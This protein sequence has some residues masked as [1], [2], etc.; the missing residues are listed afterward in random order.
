MP[1]R[2]VLMIAAMT[3][4]LLSPA[5]ARAQSCGSSADCLIAGASCVEGACRLSAP[6]TLIPTLAVAPLVLRF[7]ANLSQVAGGAFDF[8]VTFPAGAKTVAVVV[9]DAWPQYDELGQLLNPQDVLWYWRSDWK[10]VTT[11]LVPFKEGRRIEVKKDGCTL[12]TPK[13][14]AEGVYHWAALA[15]DAAGRVSHQSEVRSFSVGVERL[16]G[17]SC[18]STRDCESAASATCRENA[19]SYC[20]I[21]CASDQD[22]FAGTRCD[23]EVRN[24][25][26]FPWGVCRPPGPV[27][28][29]GDA[30]YCD[31][32][33]SRGLGL[34]FRPMSDGQSAGCDCSGGSS[35]QEAPPMCFAGLLVTTFWRITRRVRRRRKA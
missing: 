34:C 21:R 8:E 27:C 4:A 22:C 17:R 14:L 23:L 13:D 19:H 29:C 32:E 11:G 7:P 35:R 24:T 6:R 31:D 20:A 33:V 16:T 1:P 28:A 10:G 30:Q 12:Q 9:T 5:R 3:V 2:I 26:G 15:W 25:E 18:R